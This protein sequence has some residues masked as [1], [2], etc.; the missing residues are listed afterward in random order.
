MVL[1]PTKQWQRI[2]LGHSDRS[3]TIGPFKVHFMSL[4]N[5][6]LVIKG[7]LDARCPELKHE[8][9]WNDYK[10]ILGKDN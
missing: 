4:F 10:P 3:P 5:R 7:T 2:T 6:L 8:W 9:T 1:D